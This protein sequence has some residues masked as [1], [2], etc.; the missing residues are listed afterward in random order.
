MKPS[1][2][3]RL[4]VSVCFSTAS[5][6]FILP[7]A[8]DA[9]SPSVSELETKLSDPNPELRV[10][11]ARGL[12]A[13][14]A[15]AATAVAALADRLSDDV[16]TVRAHAAHALG[17]IG[18][19]AASTFTKLAAL[20]VDEDPQVRREAV[21]AMRALKVDREQLI[22]EMLKVLETSSSEEVIPAMHAI[23]EIGKDAVPALV[24]AL[25]HE[26]ARYWACEILA[27]IGPEAVAAVP[28]LAEVLKDPRIEVRREA[29]LCIGQIGVG[30]KATAPAVLAMTSDADSGTR[31]AAVWAAVM[32]GAPAAELQSRA[33]ALANDQDPMVQVVATWAVAKSAPTDAVA[34]TAAVEQATVAIKSPQPA[35]RGAAAR[36]LV[37]LQVTA[38]TDPDAIEAI[39]GSLVAYDETV[40]PVVTNALIQDGEKSVPRLLKAL[41]RPDLRGFA[42]MVLW[43]IG[44]KAKA[45]RSAIEPL[46]K[47][48]DVRLRASAVAAL[49][50]VSGDDPA[51]VAATATSLDDPHPEVRLAA[52]DSLGRLGMAAKSAEAAIVKHADDPDPVV[53]ATL[54]QVIKGL[55]Q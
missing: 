31:A 47:D 32:I 35:V 44:P 4:I 49:A 53:R 55:T 23:A 17:A 13:Q 19:A 46:T 18:P 14:G 39:I 16:P 54:A 2:L 7:R 43:E 40:T 38:E 51:V 12:A 26:D 45:A 8:V 27:L 9:E 29:V 33:A 3:H 34:R 25:G 11:A 30:A 21:I 36:V 1:F 10:Q 42:L 6:V 5:L 20:V 37:D 15:A 48:P 22:S 24:A 41:A 50:A 28:A 52:A